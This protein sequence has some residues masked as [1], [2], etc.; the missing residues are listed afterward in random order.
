MKSLWKKITTIIL[1]CLSLISLCL[2]FGNL[3]G[4]IQQE[5]L[6]ETLGIKI[7]DYPYPNSFPS[8]YYYSV[9]KPG[10]TIN[11]VHQRIKGYKKV[12]NCNGVSEIYFFYDVSDEKALRFRIR[13][14][15]QKNYKEF[16]GEEK[17]SRT[18][19]TLGCVEGQLLP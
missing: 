8:G 14:D 11:E 17:D 4:R 6:A 1:I 16:E 9:L 12:I 5:R 10:M 2:I 13:Y 18:I 19:Q 7:D 15:Q 3:Q